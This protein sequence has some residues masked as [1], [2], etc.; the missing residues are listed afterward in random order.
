MTEATSIFVYCAGAVSV[1]AFALYFIDKALAKAG[2]WR[3]P[4]KLLLFLSVLFGGVGGLAAMLLF[5]HKTKHW[6]FYFAN[7]LGI[8]LVLGVGAGIELLS[9]GNI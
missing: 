5:R 9:G 2:A 6:Y 8:L 1:L 3:I 4:E 7:V